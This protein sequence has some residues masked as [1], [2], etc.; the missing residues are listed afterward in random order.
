MA[1]NIDFSNF[2]GGMPV[3]LIMYRYIEIKC[4]E[5]K[6]LYNLWFYYGSDT[7]YRFSYYDRYIELNLSSFIKLQKRPKIKDFKHLCP[8]F[9]LCIGI[10]NIEKLQNVDK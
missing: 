10:K 7:Y 2:Q 8:F 9:L 4:N 1:E 6:K 3:F 5:V